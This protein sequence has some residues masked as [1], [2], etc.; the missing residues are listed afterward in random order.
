MKLFRIGKRLVPLWLLVILVSGASVGAYYI[1][2]TL[3]VSLEVIEPIAILNYPTQLSLY[4]GETKEFN[5]TIQNYASVN[6]S[7]TLDYYLSNT[8]YQDNFVTFSNIIYTIIPGQQDLTAWL[9]VRSDAPPVS[10]SLTINLTR[11]LYPSGLVGYWKFDERSG[12]IVYDNSGNGNNG[13]LIDNISRVNGK[14]GLALSFDGVNDYVMLGDFKLDLQKATTYMFWINTSQTRSAPVGDYA[15]RLMGTENN[16]PTTAIL[17]ELNVPELD[18]LGIFLRDDNDRKLSA[19]L[20]DP[21]DFTGTGWHHVAMVMNPKDSTIT[22]YI[23][24][25]NRDLTYFYQ[26]S[27]SNF[28]NFQYSFTFGAS[29]SQG[30]VETFYEGTLDE[31]QIYSRALSLEEV[32]AEYTNHFP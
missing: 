26:D 14:Y 15:I 29:Y 12:N 31:V 8:T 21:F 11:G 19:Y 7:I 1:W 32:K 9:I 22:I 2:Q 28:S 16:G 30:V 6:Y 25:V 10:T 23:D 3:F 27:P 17:V 20:E 4:P 24:G 13:I 5:I 18:R